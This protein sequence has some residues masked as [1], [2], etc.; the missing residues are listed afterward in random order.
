MLT[1]IKWKFVKSRLD[2]IQFLN[3][4]RIIVA[5]LHNGNNG[6]YVFSQLRMPEVI[7][8][9]PMQLMFMAASLS[10]RRFLFKLLKD[11]SAS[12][13]KWGAGLFPAFVAELTFREKVVID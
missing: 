5:E 12:T 1:A 10:S 4:V 11:I 9:P 3:E 8:E 7:R 6:L 2:P 13:G